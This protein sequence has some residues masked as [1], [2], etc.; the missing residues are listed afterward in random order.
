M[1]FYDSF[2]SSK[3]SSPNYL[4]RTPTL[5]DFQTI[6]SKKKTKNHD[7]FSYS[8]H[9][10]LLRHPTLLDLQPN[11]ENI[12]PSNFKKEILHR[13]TELDLNS[14][15]NTIGAKRKSQFL[16]SNKISR[17]KELSSPPNKSIF[18]LRQDTFLD[19]SNIQDFRSSGKLIPLNPFLS[20]IRSNFF[21]VKL[22]Y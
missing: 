16:S 17:E 1:T 5:L 7:S 13:K 19:S 8:S 15:Q 12:E 21:Q 10:K 4:L 18:L 20:E 3:S 9:I 22:F 2:I 14:I 11:Q 6:S